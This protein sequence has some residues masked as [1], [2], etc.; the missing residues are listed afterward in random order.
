MTL[1]PYF[2]V[3]AYGSLIANRGETYQT[4]PEE[5]TRDLVIAG[6]A[7]LYTAFMIYAGGMKFVLLSAVLYAPGTVLY[8]WTRREQNKTLFTPAEWVIFVVAVVGAVVGIH[9]LATGYITI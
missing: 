4:R 2:L 7:A 8:F 3:A 1:I 9:G 5:R 6:I